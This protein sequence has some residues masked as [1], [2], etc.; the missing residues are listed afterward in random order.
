MANLQ[1]WQTKEAT[2]KYKRY[3]HPDKKETYIFR[4]NGDVVKGKKISAYYMPQEGETDNT[5]YL[6]DFKSKGDYYNLAY[7]ETVKPETISKKDKTKDKNVSSFYKNNKL[8][9]LIGGGIF[10]A[11]LIGFIVY[12]MRSN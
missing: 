10:T 3:E 12:K 7:L 8:P 11:I 6:E 4:E 5:L 9:L 2:K 1:T